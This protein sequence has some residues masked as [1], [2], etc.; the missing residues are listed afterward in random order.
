MGQ[1]KLIQMLSESGMDP[2][3]IA[4][5][6]GTNNNVVSA[7]LGRLKKQKLRKKGK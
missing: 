1:A 6:I 7:T 2:K 3:D 5:V 4:S